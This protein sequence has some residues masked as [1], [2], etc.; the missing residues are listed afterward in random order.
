M[1]LELGQVNVGINYMIVDSCCYL[2]DY[3]NADIM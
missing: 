1:N 2:D 3:S